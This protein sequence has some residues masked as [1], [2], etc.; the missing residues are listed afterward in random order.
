MRSAIHWL[1]PCSGGVNLPLYLWRLRLIVSTKGCLHV[2]D[3]KSLKQLHVLQAS[4]EGPGMTDSQCNAEHPLIP[5][6]VI[7]TVVQGCMMSVNPQIKHLWPS[8]LQRTLVSPAL[9]HCFAAATATRLMPW[10]HRGCRAV[11]H[12]IAVGALCCTGPQRAS[13]SHCFITVRYAARHCLREGET[14]AHCCTHAILVSYPAILTLF[15]GCCGAYLCLFVPP[16]Y[17]DP[18]VFNRFW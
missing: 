2:F 7:D 17:P 1:E 8:N 13:H 10:L 12:C 16:G 18:C 11:Q 9:S 14:N 3:L 5:G 6:A 15:P 4:E